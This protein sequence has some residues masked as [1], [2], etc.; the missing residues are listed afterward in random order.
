MLG[1]IPGAADKSKYLKGLCT[2]TGSA[3]GQVVRAQAYCG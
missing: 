2:G 1:S 3:A